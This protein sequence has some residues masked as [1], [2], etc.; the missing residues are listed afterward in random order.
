MRILPLLNRNIS[1]G[2]MTTVLGR[3]QSRRGLFS[4]KGVPPILTF[5]KF[6]FQISW[7]LKSEAKVGRRREK[8]KM[9]K[10][11]NMKTSQIYFMALT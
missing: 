11:K 1:Q 3:N 2:I 8:D 10:G 7:N 9:A 6:V 5:S 4:A